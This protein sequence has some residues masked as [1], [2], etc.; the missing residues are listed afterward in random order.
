MLTRKN[1]A[2]SDA[3]KISPYTLGFLLIVLVGLPISS[4]AQIGEQCPQLESALPRRQMGVE[5]RTIREQ[6][7]K[8]CIKDNKKD[9]EELVERTETISKLS[10]EI[11][12]SFETN[13]RLSDADVAKLKEVEDLV[14][15]VRSELRAEDDDED[16][17]LKPE[18]LMDAV[19]KL[20]EQ[21]GS[22]LT[23]IKKTTRFSVSLI[24]VQSSNSVM[25]IVKF[26]R[27]SD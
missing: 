15:K 23:E 2:R 10:D 21:A 3:M 6:L 8:M 9:F 11:K 13:Q 26:L 19:G 16:D 18:N 14:K 22:L 5:G 24:A 20:Q 17:E 25:R 1:D 27:L 7:I 4:A 12:A